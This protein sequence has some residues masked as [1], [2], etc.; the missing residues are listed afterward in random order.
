MVGR[1]KTLIVAAALLTSCLTVSAQRDLKPALDSIESNR[2]LDHVR[3]LASDKFEGR[4]PGTRGEDLTVEYLVDQFKRAGLTPGNPDGTFIQKVPLVGYQTVPQL[5]VFSGGQKLSLKF[6][7]DFVHDF[8]ALRPSARVGNVPIVFAGYGIVAPEY[9]WDDYNGVDVRGKLVLVLSGE[10][11]VPDKSDPKKLDANVFRGETRTYY[12][13]RESKFDIAAKKGAAGVL[14]IYDP[15]KAKTFSLFQTFAKME[16]FAIKPQDRN[17]KTLISGLITTNASRR[18]FSATGRDLDQLEKAAKLT[19]FRAVECDGRA[20]IAVTSKLRNVVSRNVV[21]RVEGSDPK[22]RSEYIVYSAHWD[23]LGRDP[24]LKGD[25]IYNGAMDNAIGTAQLLEIARAFAMST[26]K[27]KRSILFIAVTAEE[28]GYLGSRY[29]VQHPL[30]PISKSVA[31]INLDG[32]NAWGVTR[33]LL[34]ANYGLSTLDE[35]LEVAA[36][37]QNRSFTKESVDDGGLYF[38]SD[39]VEFAK[40]GIPAIFPFSGFEYVG[41]PKDFAD[42]KWEAY[43]AND[44]HQVSDELRPDWDLSGAAEDA[45]WLLIAGANVANSATRPAWKRGVEFRRK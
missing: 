31:N 1:L 27:P 14:V 22:L 13:T 12:S 44:Y 29:Y 28:K 10:P 33:D 21:A 43:S 15:E 23:H 40:A 36:K 41:K 45:K 35:V 19:G 34:T 4:A 20:N 39:Q 32:G 8:P 25:P 38:G 7:D 5:D 18:L 42:K 6:L 16:G 24:N 2:I 3:I 11:Q 30:F 26:K 17:T 37:A 9:G